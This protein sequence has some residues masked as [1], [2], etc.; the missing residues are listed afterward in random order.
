MTCLKKVSFLFG[1]VLA[2]ARISCPRNFS[3]KIMRESSQSSC[4]LINGAFLFH[5]SAKLY[6]WLKL[7][8][9]KSKWPS[10]VSF[11]DV[12]LTCFLPTT[13]KFT[14]CLELSIITSRCVKFMQL[15]SYR[16][17]DRAFQQQTSAFANI[18]LHSVLR[19]LQDL[20]S[21]KTQD[22]LSNKG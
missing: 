22:S 11:T 21:I 1:Q 9:L 13:K 7:S 10:A 20:T 12:S 2:L 17:Y 14:D 18:A 8:S 5:Y 4:S 16:T 19:H 3:I 15:S 6:F